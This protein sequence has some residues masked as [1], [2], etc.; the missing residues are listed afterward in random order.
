MHGSASGHLSE[1]CTR[2]GVACDEIS[3]KRDPRFGGRPPRNTSSRTST[4]LRQAVWPEKRMTP[5]SR[6]R[7]RVT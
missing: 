4:A 5:A 3:G 7:R 6:R 2:N 1:L